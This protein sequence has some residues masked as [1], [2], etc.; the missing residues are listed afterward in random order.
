MREF[1]A[2]FTIEFKALMREPVSLFFMIVLP[3]IFTIVFGG[4]FGREVT[5][6]GKDILG[7]DTIVPT[8]VV[9]LLTNV[10]L[11]GVPITIIELKDQEVLKRYITYPIKFRTYFIALISVFA[12]VGLLSTCIFTVI[13]IIVYGARWH[14]GI[15]ETLLFLLLYGAMIVIFDGLGFLIALLVKGSR[16][17]NMVTSG[18][19][20]SLIFTSGVVMPVE[21][22]P[23]AVQ[24]IAYIFPMYHCI[25][26]AQYLWISRVNLNE[27][28]DNIIYISAITIVFFVLLGRLK[29][30]WD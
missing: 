22:L 12:F 10:G 14:M 30:K 4:A 29:V 13:S 7:I 27:I 28:A 15:S 21:S 19:F 11:M 16:T 26:I 20:L 24:K 2:F 8:N 1:K 5:N 6:Y 25:Q 23:V 9:F 18:L 3:I 17:A